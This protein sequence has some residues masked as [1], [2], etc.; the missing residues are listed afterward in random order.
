MRSSRRQIAA[1]TL[2]L[3]VFSISCGNEKAIDSVADRPPDIPSN[4]VPADG[5]IDQSLDIQLSWECSDPDGDSLTYRLY[6]SANP[7]PPIIDSALM[8]NAYIIEALDYHRIYY[9]SVEASDGYQHYTQSPIWS[10]T[11]RRESGIY[12]VGRYNVPHPGDD[13]FITGGYAFLCDYIN[14]S[15]YLLLIINLSDPADPVL[16]GSYEDTSIRGI[17]VRGDLGFIIGGTTFKILD[18]SVPSNPILLNETELFWPPNGLYLSSDYAYIPSFQYLKIVD[19]SDFA[20]PVLIT[21]YPV[22]P[23]VYD[24][25]VRGDYAYVPVNGH[26][27]LIIDISNPYDPI[28]IGTYECQESFGK[29]SVQGNYVYL[30]DHYDGLLVIDISIPSNPILVGSYDHVR[31]V[32]VHGD[33]A[34]GS[35]GRYLIK[36]DISDPAELMEITRYRMRGNVY[37]IAVDD[38][39]I[40]TLDTEIGFSIL[41]YV[42]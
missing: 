18:L 14:I 35:W 17:F 25:F 28:L 30:S 22:E 3:W 13:L 34:Y 5:A 11:T 2:G 10:L 24:I 21:S 19:I 32:V 39:Y 16:A 15:Q 9:W 31:N 40:Y 41:E 6:F 33:F 4:P 37:N 8:A 42:P 12:L 7:D 26:G 1:V 29:I 27:L 38:N 20:N 23:F 36:F